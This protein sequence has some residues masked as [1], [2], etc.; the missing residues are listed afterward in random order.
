MKATMLIL[1]AMLYLSAC[2]TVHHHYEGGGPDQAQAAD[3]GERIYNGL[4]SRLP[5]GQVT[6]TET[7]GFIGKYKIKVSTDP[8]RP[9]QAVQ[10]WRKGPGET[11][12]YNVFLRKASDAHYL[13]ESFLD[14]AL[15]AGKGQFHPAS[16]GEQIWVDFGLP[17]TTR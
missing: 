12:K 16:V 11:I 10:A 7:P 8:S 3:S 6:P 2:T 1:G 17:T 4:S 5:A 14:Q 15:S 13:T 9:K